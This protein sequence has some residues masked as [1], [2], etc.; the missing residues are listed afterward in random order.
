MSTVLEMTRPEWDA[1]CKDLDAVRMLGGSLA[2]LLE[3]ALDAEW[4]L[5]RSA[6]GVEKTEPEE[7][8]VHYRE[9]ADNIRKGVGRLVR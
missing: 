4:M 5:R 2:E 7:L 8:R 9:I 3:A 6:D 1:Y